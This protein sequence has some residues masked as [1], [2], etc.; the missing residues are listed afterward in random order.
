MLYFIDSL[1]AGGKER[2]LDELINHSIATLLTP[3]WLE[4]L[5]SKQV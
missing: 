2:Q 1:K 3:G 5:K 4:Y